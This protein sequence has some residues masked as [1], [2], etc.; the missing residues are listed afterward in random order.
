MIWPT[1]ISEKGF[2]QSLISHFS[3]KLRLKIRWVFQ[4]ISENLRMEDQLISVLEA[5]FEVL[6]KDFPELCFW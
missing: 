3:S 1:N 4:I 5:K 2:G 6:D